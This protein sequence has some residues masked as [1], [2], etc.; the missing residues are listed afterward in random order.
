MAVAVD[1]VGIQAHNEGH[2][3]AKN[4]A[5]IIGGENVEALHA[6]GYRIVPAIPT[7][8]MR[9]AATE[10]LGYWQPELGQP[11]L[12]SDQKAGL[13]YEAMLKAWRGDFDGLSKWREPPP[14]IHWKLRKWLEFS[15]GWKTSK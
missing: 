10:L 2:A 6:A 13:R 7:K 4:P 8:T 3:A 5:S 9:R 15:I 1:R 14:I 12:T 11:Y